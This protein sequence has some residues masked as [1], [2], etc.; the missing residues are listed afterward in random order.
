MQKIIGI[1]PARYGSSRFP[2]KPLIDI[3]GK[4]MIERVYLQAKHARNLSEVIVAT[5]DQRIYDA[6]KS[7]AGNV[8]LTDSAHHSGTDRCA[9]VL[10]KVQGFDIAINIQ[11]DEPFIDP[12]QIDLLCDCFV[13]EQ[14][15]IATLIR[16]IQE[17]ETLFDPNK[18]KVVIDKNGK[19]LYFSRSPIPFLKDYPKDKW[20]ENNK[21][22]SHI[23]IYGYRKSSLEQITQIPPSVLENAESLEQLRWLENGFNIQTPESIHTNDAIDTPE[24]LEHILKKYFNS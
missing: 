3:G 2:G 7:F 4:T 15:D 19:A 12:L 14:T 10:S 18:V 16:P 17:E 20:L 6:V 21:Y 24:D 8:V 5:D 22:F 13:N 23:G 9:E 1:I 11:G